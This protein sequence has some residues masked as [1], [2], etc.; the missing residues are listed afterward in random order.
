MLIAFTHANFIEDYN[1]IKLD[2]EFSNTQLD[3]NISNKQ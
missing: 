3:K 2:I 1:N